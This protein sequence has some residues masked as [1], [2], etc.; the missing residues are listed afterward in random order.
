MSR[1]L[2]T[3]F[4]LIFLSAHISFSQTVSNADQKGISPEIRKDAVVL[5]RETS[6]EVNTLR[7]LENRISFFSGTRRIDVV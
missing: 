3:P 5:L 1:K 7:T 2:F 6:A 4:L